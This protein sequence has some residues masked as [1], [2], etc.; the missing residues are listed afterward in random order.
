MASVTPFIMCEHVSSVVSGHLHFLYSS[1]K[2]PKAEAAAV[3]LWG[4]E[5]FLRRVCVM[6]AL[7]PLLSIQMQASE[8]VAEDAGGR[9]ME[10]SKMPDRIGDLQCWLFFRI[11]GNRPA[12]RYGRQ[13]LLPSE[14]L[15][16]HSAAV[17]GPFVEE[18]ADCQAESEGI[19]CSGERCCSRPRMQDP[20]MGCR[21]PDQ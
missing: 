13:G 16:T 18:A 8:M 2:N 11:Q 10:M 14:G 12:Q 5:L 21:L 1:D 17:C 3:T 20:W 15:E 4:S 9:S 19:F 6:K 7:T